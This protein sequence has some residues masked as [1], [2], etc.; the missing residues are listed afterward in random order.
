MHVN[1]LDG[2]ESIKVFPDSYFKIIF[3]VRQGK[4]VDYFMTGLW[5]EGQDYT[6]AQDTTVYGCRFKILAPE[7]LLNREVG[8]LLQSLVQ[9]EL[10][11]LNLKDLDLSSFSLIVKQWERELRKIRSHKLIEG[12]KLRLSQLLYQTNGAITASEVSRQIFWTNRQI[13]RYLNK[14][15]GVSLKKYLN[16][17]KCYEAYVQIREGRFFPDKNYF[18]QAHFIKEVRKHTGETPKKL[19]ER[20]NDRFIQLK[21]IKRK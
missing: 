2:P 16:V 20:Q 13:T 15:L 4:V 7:Y 11:Y 6:L 1:T 5:I 8:K 12:K 10:S 21:N 19:Y 9:L 18:D 17:Q 14:Y 3:S